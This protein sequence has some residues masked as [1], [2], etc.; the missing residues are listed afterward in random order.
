MQSTEWVG[1][2]NRL[3][4]A[5]YVETIIALCENYMNDFSFFPVDEEKTDTLNSLV[6]ASFPYTTT[7]LPISV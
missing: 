4:G 1:K 7:E 6:L 2:R 3:C 5:G